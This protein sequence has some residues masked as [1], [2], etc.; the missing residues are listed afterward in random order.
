MRKDCF[1]HLIAHAHQRIQGGHGLLE[2]HSHRAPAKFA[3]PLFRRGEQFFACKAD[4]SANASL[5]SQQSHD[6][7]RRSRFAAPRFAH[8]SDRLTLVNG[9]VE[10]TDSGR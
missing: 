1:G 8:Q 10:V 4:A 2:D 6:R 3:H 5:R 9:E 7:Q